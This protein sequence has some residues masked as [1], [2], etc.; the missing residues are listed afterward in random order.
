MNLTH[1]HTK[2]GDTSPTYRS[3]RAMLKRCNDSKN[4]RYQMYGGRGIRVCSRWHVFENF[5]ADMGERPKG[6][7]LDRI[8]PNGHY[9]PENCRWA[10]IAEQVSNKRNSRV[11]EYNGER[12]T[13]AEWGRRLGSQ[14]IV[15]RRVRD[16][17]SEKDAVSIPPKSL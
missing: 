16:G 12:L 4:N 1:G 5:L 9:S 6:R 2:G 15:Y 17:W 8:D 11:F 7:T 14:N 3:W 10:T 13:Y